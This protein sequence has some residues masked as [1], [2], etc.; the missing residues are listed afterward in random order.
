MA[1]S[2]RIPGSHSKAI[3][4]LE[5]PYARVPLC[6]LVSE[7]HL[8]PFADSLH[9]LWF[10]LS[11]MGCFASKPVDTG[12]KDSGQRNARIEKVLRNDKKVMDRTIKILLLGKSSRGV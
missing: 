10:Q 5:Y 4:R 6:I 2:E 1:Q 11:K 12:E 7:L 3:A 9:R 8:T